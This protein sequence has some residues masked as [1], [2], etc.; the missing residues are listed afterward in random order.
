[1]Y[2]LLVEDNDIV[3]DGIKQGLETLG[4]STDWVKDAHTAKQAICVHSTYN[5]TQPMRAH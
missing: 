4:H 2:I 1:M 5:A 3:G